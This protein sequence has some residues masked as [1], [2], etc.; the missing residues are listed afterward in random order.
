M[1][2]WLEVYPQRYVDFNYSRVN[3]CALSSVLTIFLSSPVNQFGW[4]SQT[5]RGSESLDTRAF[6]LAS[7]YLHHF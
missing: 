4:Q 6:A 1:L 7:F 2:F 5:I 3:V